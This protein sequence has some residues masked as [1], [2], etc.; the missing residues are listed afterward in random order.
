MPGQRI[1]RATA[2]HLT[3]DDFD[4][5]VMGNGFINL[6][7]GF[8]V[9]ISGPLCIGNFQRHC[10]EELQEGALALGCYGGH[11]CL[12]ATFWASILL[13]STDITSGSNLE[14]RRALWWGLVVSPFAGG[15]VLLV[16]TLT[17]RA[18][19]S[20]SGFEVVLP[21]DSDKSP[22]SK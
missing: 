12:A 9:G 21:T 7:V 13:P 8:L 16:G 11:V 6:S 1:K 18:K 19:F 22:S 15:V 20:S 10:Q 17:N 5:A 2:S 3:L 14:L 4:D